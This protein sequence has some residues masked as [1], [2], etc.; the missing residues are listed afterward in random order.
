MKFPEEMLNR[1]IDNDGPN[2]NEDLSL[3]KKMQ[4][5]DEF[6][7]ELPENKF[8]LGTTPGH[9]SGSLAQ[10]LETS[11]EDLQ[12]IK[13]KLS[14]ETLIDLGCGEPG[15]TDAH[16]KELDISLASYVGV[17]KK[18]FDQRWVEESRKQ[19]GFPVEYINEDLL[20]FV[21]KIPDNSAN[22]LISG[23]DEDVLRDSEYRKRLMAEIMRATKQ[24]GLVLNYHGALDLSPRSADSSFQAH[25]GNISGLSIHVKNG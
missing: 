16:L 1:N 18:E 9:F 22:F 17:D 24:G 12:F 3:K 13:E 11:Q 23:I 14:G 19:G 25:K 6:L 20:R 2:L 5:V 15:Y 10:N 4:E 7:E 21:S 8:M